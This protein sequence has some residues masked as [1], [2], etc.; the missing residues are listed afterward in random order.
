MAS[1]D[2]TNDFILITI[3]ESRK[4]GMDF[5]KRHEKDQTVSWAWVTIK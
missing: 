4:K 1:L 2:S 3:I 5:F